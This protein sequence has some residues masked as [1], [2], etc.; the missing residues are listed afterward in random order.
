MKSPKRNMVCLFISLLVFTFSFESSRGHI[1][2]NAENQ[3]ETRLVIRKFDEYEMNQASMGDMKARLDGFFFELQK[4][5]SSRAHIFIY[6][7][8][9]EVP[10]YRAGAIRDYLA[11][12][13][14]KSS[15]LKIVRGGHRAVP[16]VEFWIVP[17]GGEAPRATPP[18][19]P[20]RKKR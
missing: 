14:L 10:R 11:L 7:S 18:S 15:R 19:A 17:Q 16:M 1:P 4:E 12:R 8:K 5:P 20:I 6:G 13:G 3:E 9:Q 2:N